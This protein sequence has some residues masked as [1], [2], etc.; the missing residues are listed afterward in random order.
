[1]LSR[2]EQRRSLD[3]VIGWEHQFPASP[4][5]QEVLLQC[6]GRSLLRLMLLLLPL[7]LQEKVLLH[8]FQWIR[9]Y[10]LLVSK[11]VWQM[12]RGMCAKVLSLHMIPR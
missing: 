10:R 8:G 6:R 1:M 9:R 3:R 5:K 7:Y 12:G 2:K 4:L 11:S